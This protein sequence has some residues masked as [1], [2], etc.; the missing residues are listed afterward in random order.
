MLE[1]QYHQAP[2][3]SYSV[4]FNS[5]FLPEIL[6]TP[7]KAVT[8]LGEKRCRRY[9]S[10]RHSLTIDPVVEFGIIAFPRTVVLE[11]IRDIFGPLGV[12]IARKLAATVQNLNAEFRIRL[13]FTS[14]SQASIVPFH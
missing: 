1:L 5:V 9:N 7:P 6:E 13:D 4:D 3:N 8:K 2:A 10:R 11:K 14:G 12:S